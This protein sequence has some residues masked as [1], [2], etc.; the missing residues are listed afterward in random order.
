MVDIA[1][2]SVSDQFGLDSLVIDFTIKDTREDL[3]NYRFDLYKSNHQTEPYFV[4]AADITTFNYRDFDVNLYNI[5][6]NFYYKVKVTDK[7]TGDSVLSETYGEYKQARADVNALAILEIHNIYLDNVVGNK[8][9][10]LKKKRTGQVCSCFDDVRRRSNPVFCSI[11]YGTKYTGGYY[12]PFTV[13]VNFLNP[14]TK[15]EYFAPN[16]V[17]EWEGTPLQLW[18]QNYPLIQIQDIMVDYNNNIRYV[19]TNSHPSYMNFYLIRQTVQVQR[20]PDS[21]VVYQYPISL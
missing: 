3:S 17:G 11:C 12:S 15:V 8:M 9:I 10:L 2:I 19:V 13:P 18:T 14:P 20:L 4:I 7:T 5:S 21:N 6:I 16:D 1:S